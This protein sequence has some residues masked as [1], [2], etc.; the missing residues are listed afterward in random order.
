MIYILT[1][2]RKKGEEY[3]RRRGL[4]PDTAV[5][6]VTV[7]DVQGRIYNSKDAIIPIGDYDDMILFELTVGR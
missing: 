3:L 7:E 6:C 4:D 2:S 1:D 5:I